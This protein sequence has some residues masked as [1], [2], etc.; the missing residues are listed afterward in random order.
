MRGI[1][2]QSTDIVRGLLD[3]RRQI[4]SFLPRRPG[5]DPGVAHTRFVNLDRVALGSD[6][7]QRV[8]IF[9]CSITIHSPSK[10]GKIGPLAVAVSKC[11]ASSHT[12]AHF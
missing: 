2:N 5:F 4:A 7:P 9:Q 12:V 1:T 10:A 6:P 11:A 3:L 8:N